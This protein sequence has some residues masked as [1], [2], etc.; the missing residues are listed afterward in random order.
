MKRQTEKIL[1]V[2]ELLPGD[3]FYMADENFFDSDRWLVDNTYPCIVPDKPKYDDRIPTFKFQLLDHHDINNYPDT[4]LYVT[5]VN[6]EIENTVAILGLALS[7]DELVFQQKNEI[8]DKPAQIQD[9]LDRIT[10]KI[11]SFPDEPS[12]AK[13]WLDYTLSKLTKYSKLLNEVDN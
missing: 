5:L 4:Q 11:T 7:K 8:S 13:S 2:S 6:I 1:K 12:N 9:M 10:Q 3:I